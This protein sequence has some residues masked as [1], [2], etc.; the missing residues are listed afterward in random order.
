MKVSNDI[1][2][3]AAAA[4]TRTNDAPDGNDFAAMLAALAG[5]VGTPTVVADAAT[6]ISLSAPAN[7][8]TVT[9]S[10]TVIDLTTL[11]DATASKAAASASAAGIAADPG[12]PI[13]P[14]APSAPG[15]PGVAST[16]ASAEPSPVEM[17]LT[18]LSI[19]VLPSTE[20]PA[21]SD[22]AA[23][24]TGRAA[25]AKPEI[26]VVAPGTT[27][28]ASRDAAK[29]TPIEL[30]TAIPI[31][32][33]APTATAPTVAAPTNDAANIARAAAFLGGS[34]QRTTTSIGPPVESTAKRLDTFDTTEIFSATTAPMPTP[35]P[36]STIDVRDGTAPKMVIAPSRIDTVAVAAARASADASRPIRLSVRLDPPSL[37]ELRVE[38]TVRG[39]QV[40][41][42]L[43]P[44]GSTAVP[45][46]AAQREAIAAALERTGFQLSGFDI[47]NPEQQHQAFNQKAATSRAGNVDEVDEDQLAEEQAADGLRI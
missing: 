41:V 42:R 38:V 16:P 30:P 40:S 9:S 43:E 28:G 4:D 7:T 26:L 25:F 27:P 10:T 46:L 22:L 2:M 19:S 15:A 24:L 44:T 5:I 31:P 37:G 8:P 45:R 17:I 6:S 23:A 1:A 32:V 20:T 18:D 13:A 36:V 39:G 47:A 3:P 11:V 35:V 34:D 12:S 14:G 21:A 29:A 33:V